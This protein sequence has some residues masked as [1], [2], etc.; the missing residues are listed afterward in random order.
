MQ[1]NAFLQHHNPVG[2][3]AQSAYFFIKCQNI[4]LHVYRFTSVQ[5]C[6]WNLSLKVFKAFM[7]PPSGKQRHAISISLQF[8]HKAMDFK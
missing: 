2:I 4:K 1:M 7:Q 8:V 5:S 6:P 3:W